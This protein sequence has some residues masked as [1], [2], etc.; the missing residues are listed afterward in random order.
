M[1]WGI[2]GEEKQ[3]TIAPGMLPLYPER[4]HVRWVRDPDPATLDRIHRQALGRQKGLGLSRPLPRWN[5][6]IRQVRDAFLFGPPDAPQG[7]LLSRFRKRAPE[8]DL[9]RYDLEVVEMDWTTPE[10][11][12]GLLGFL[13]SQR[14]QVQEV[15][16][17]WP[18]EG[19]LDSI[20]PNPARQGINALPGHLHPGPTVGHGIMVRLE[21]PAQAFRLRPYRGTEALALE[22]E[23]RDP[24]RDDRVI[25]F[26]AVLRGDEQ[27]G[28]AAVKPQPARLV[29]GL[30]TLSSLWAGA[31]RVEEAVAF[32][33]AEVSPASAA[34][35]LDRLLEVPRP[36]VVERF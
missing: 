12:R 22:V 7:Y 14:D 18:R 36:W 28:S 27:S 32:G 1:G 23:T 26:K 13:S 8:G 21:D 33:L 5:W 17:Q 29:T 11:M 15:L 4:R 24:L 34:P 2:I 19:N 30:A 16:L 31:L 6:M 20:L 10:A 35:I 25:A 3:Y 9:L